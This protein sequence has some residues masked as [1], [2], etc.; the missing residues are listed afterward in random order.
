MEL[1]SS[2]L[3]I[4]E[5]FLHTSPL[6]IKFLMQNSEHLPKLKQYRKIHTKLWIINK[7]HPFL[8]IIIKAI[9]KKNSGKK[10]KPL[11]T[12]RITHKASGKQIIPVLANRSRSKNRWKY[13]FLER[14]N[15][16]D[17]GFWF[18]EETFHICL[19]WLT[20]INSFFS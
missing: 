5:K 6:S 7:T 20:K 16:Q 1:W 19:F 9:T 18:S 15:E 4:S 10:K 12:D 11:G 2:K 14:E 3:N 17:V 13:H 8:S